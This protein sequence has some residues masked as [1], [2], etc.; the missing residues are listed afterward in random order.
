MIDFIILRKASIIGLGGIIY[1]SSRL[2]TNM[3]ELEENTKV[4]KLFDPMKA[5]AQVDVYKEIYNLMDEE[6]SKLKKLPSA[7]S[8]KERQKIKDYFSQEKLSEIDKE[9]LSKE[10]SRLQLEIDSLEEVKSSHQGFKF[11]RTTTSKD[12]FEDALYNKKFDDK[13]L[14]NKKNMIGED[15]KTI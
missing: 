15:P 11:L 8:D 3:K 1:L 5:K 12:V 6:E 10:L 9:K 14:K 4:H 2:G 7:V 13:F